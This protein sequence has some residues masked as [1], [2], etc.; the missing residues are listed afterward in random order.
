MTIVKRMSICPSL[1]LSLLTRLNTV[2]QLPDFVLV[3][4]CE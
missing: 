4:A 3:D 2:E 1:S